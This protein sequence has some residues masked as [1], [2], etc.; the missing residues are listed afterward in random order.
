MR[1]LLIIALLAMPLM[2]RDF[3]DRKAEPGFE[4]TL[5]FDYKSVRGV[6]RKAE[7]LKGGEIY[8]RKQGSKE[9]LPASADF[10]PFTRSFQNIKVAEDATYEL[11]EVF[12]LL[13]D[14]PPKADTPAQ[15]TIIIDTKPP[16]VE[17]LA[18]TTDIIKWGTVPTL[19]YTATDEFID[20]NRAIDVYADG[21]NGL[22]ALATATPNNGEF[23]LE[24]NN[25]KGEY[26]TVFL[27]VYDRAGNVASE[28]VS[29]TFGDPKPVLPKKKDVP[30]R[31]KPVMQISWGT[32][33]RIYHR[34]TD[35]YYAVTNNTGSALHSVQVFFSTDDGFT[36]HFGGKNSS[37]D[38]ED[39][40]TLKIPYA[41]RRNQKSGSYEQIRLAF[42]AVTEDG[43]TSRPKPIA[44]DSGDLTAAVDMAPP[45]VVLES[46][47]QDET[48]HADD[49]GF[50]LREDKFVVQWNAT[51]K[52][53]EPLAVHSKWR[54]GPVSVWY[55]TQPDSQPFSES[56]RRIA[57]DLAATDSFTGKLDLPLS[58]KLILA[59]SAEDEMGNISVAKSGVFTLKNRDAK[60]PDL[61]EN[62]A[63]QNADKHWTKAVKQQ[64]SGQLRQAISE[65]DKALTYGPNRADIIHDKGTCLARLN[66][67]ADAIKL[68][69]RAI[70]LEPEALGFRFSYASHLFVQGKLKLSQAALG[71]IMKNDNAEP[72]IGAR[73]LLAEIHRKAGRMDDAQVMW[74]FVVKNASKN[75]S[76][77][78]LAKGNLKTLAKASK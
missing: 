2:A 19:T 4:N 12:P 22:R 65:Y 7:I 25:A 42:L 75:S 62:L 56:W 63:R 34:E 14:N 41:L 55:S 69:E 37:G 29:F 36:W 66:R 3:L 31:D 59:V 9:W 70:E 5:H 60:E 47:H 40:V 50:L 18:P 33:S 32:D 6:E 28:A 24:L 30:A 39:F 15:Q 21:S 57:R 48:Y 49:P 51:D 54:R 72:H 71:E 68:F 44:G 27:V 43:I 67:S 20:I 38:D 64:N 8:I 16:A 73:M 26:Y 52:N 53:L 13:G 23:I 74:S 58:E 17:I 45:F 35:F 77:Y 10:D 61:R 46:P 76:D 11:F 1:L 78:K